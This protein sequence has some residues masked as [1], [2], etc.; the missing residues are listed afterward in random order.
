MPCL[1][2]MMAGIFPRLGTVILWLA[3][4]A[5]FSSA[6]GGSW[7]IPLLG[8]IFLPFTTLMYAILWSPIGL[9]TWDWIWLLFAVLVDVMHYAS[10][11]Y[12]NRGQMPGYSQSSSP[13][14][15]GAPMPYAM[16]TNTAQA[17]NTAIE[18]TPTP[19]VVTGTTTEAEIPGTPP[20]DP[21]REV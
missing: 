15:T 4:P 21:G 13:S 6:F 8:I 11:V 7:F 16:A 20:V 2:A 1:F 17:A 3:R 5:M 18:T 14:Q 12:S 9:T 10:T 19:Y